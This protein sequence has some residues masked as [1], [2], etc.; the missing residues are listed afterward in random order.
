MTLADQIRQR[1]VGYFGPVNR[2]KPFSMRFDEELKREL[3]RLA[4]AENRSLT[5]YVETVLRKHVAEQKR[6]RK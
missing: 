5:N 1:D 6:P 2:T 3:L 4:N